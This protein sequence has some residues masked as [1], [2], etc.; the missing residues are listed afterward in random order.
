MNTQATNAEVRIPQQ[1]RARY[2]AAMAAQKAAQEA[3]KAAG[4]PTSIPTEA[5]QP[6][7]PP[8]PAPEVDPIEAHLS[9][10]A[11]ALKAPEG[12]GEDVNYWRSRANAMN[13][14]LK[15][16]T[17]RAN[18][19]AEKLDAAQNELSA[20]KAAPPPAVTTGT[21]D[22]KQLGLNEEQI[23]DFGEDRLAALVKAAITGAT[24]QAT[25][26]V[27]QEFKQREDQTK[28]TEEQ[29]RYATYIENLDKEVPQWRALNE[30]AVWNGFLTQQD[31]ETGESYLDQM[32]R[33]DAARNAKGIKFLVERFGKSLG[34]ITKPTPPVS[35]LPTGAGG[36]NPAPPPQVAPQAPLDTAEIRNGYKM[37]S[38]GKWTKEQ[39]EA[40]HARVNAQLSRT[41]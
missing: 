22:L 36:S 27:R 16:S 25:T 28:Q 12:K 5:S 1:V 33:F 37:I 15:A 30:D 39:A 13:G 38:L 20:L 26:A 23:E 40:F 3:Q 10:S 35:Q 31:P 4:L 7:N 8:P 21:I 24:Q 14:L 34:A 9:Q 32:R 6:A 17:L 11:D 29:K 19:L 2:E 18:Q 41:T